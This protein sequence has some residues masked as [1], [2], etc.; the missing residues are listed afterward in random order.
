VYGMVAVETVEA[1][2]GTHPFW[3]GE[4]NAEDC[5]ATWRKAYARLFKQAGVNGH[6]HQF[7]TRSN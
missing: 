3:T 4:S 7:P 1:I 2:P 5:A 6:P